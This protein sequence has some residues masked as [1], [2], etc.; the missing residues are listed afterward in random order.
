[1]AV[2]ASFVPRIKG[3]TAEVRGSAVR[4]ANHLAFFHRDIDLGASGIAKHVDD[5]CSDGLFQHF[6]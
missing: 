6:G 4:A 3:F 5:S 2:E 1:M